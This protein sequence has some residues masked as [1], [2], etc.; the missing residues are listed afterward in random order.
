MHPYLKW[1]GGKRQLADEL[2]KR[3][4]K[5]FNRYIEPFV[6][7]GAVF[8]EYYDQRDK[9]FV[10]TD[11]IASWNNERKPGVPKALLND[12]NRWLMNCYWCL[13][14][15]FGALVSQLDKIIETNKYNTVELYADI[16]EKFQP[17][18]DTGKLTDRILCA[19]YFI[20]INKTCFNGI[21]RLNGSGKYNVPW[22][23]RTELSLYNLDN[24]K[25]CS[26]LLAAYNDS[27]YK[28]RDFFE[29]V[30]GNA[31]EGDFVFLDPP[32]IPISATSS[33]SDYTENGWGDEDN[34]R[35]K[36]MMDILTRRKVL[37]MMTNSGSEHVFE[38][39]GEY[40]IETVKAHRFV[41]AIKTEKERRQKVQET[42]VTNYD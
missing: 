21:W 13:V 22:N 4:P 7:S 5:N 26:E 10:S 25:R 16:R 23:N 36:K 33:F 8:F 1:A 17:L 30:M 20:Y 35:V 11:I 39:F 27:D 38:L 14:Y 18:L 29:F 2:I 37:F 40:N 24:L 15:H 31:A 42:V 34:H 6:G 28:S 32:Y 19:A 41:K 9:D 3:F 12:F